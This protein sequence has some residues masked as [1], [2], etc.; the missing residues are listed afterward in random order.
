MNTVLERRQL[1]NGNSFFKQKTNGK[2]EQKLQNKSF[3]IENKENIHEKINE[4]ASKNQ[5]NPAAR[6]MVKAGYFQPRKE[7]SLV[8]DYKDILSK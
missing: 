6:L 3:Y 8:S 4:A 1:N 5:S 7:I 2:S